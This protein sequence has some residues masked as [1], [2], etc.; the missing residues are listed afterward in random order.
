MK[1]LIA[2]LLVLVMVTAVFVGCSTEEEETTTAAPETT[3]QAP[4]TTTE[5]PET[6]TEETPAEKTYNVLLLVPKTG[7]KSYFDGAALGMTLLEETYDNVTTEIITMGSTDEDMA[8]YPTFFRDACESGKYDLIVTGAAECTNALVEVAAEYPDQL[9]FDFD[10][11][12]TFGNE[13]PNVYG[14]YYKTYDMGYLAGFL[15][16]QI[17]T[18]DM[19]YANEQKVIGAVVGIDFP[20]LNDFVGSFCQAAIDCGVQAI[21]SYCNTFTE[22]QPAYDC[23]MEL[24]E[25]G[26]DVVWQVAGSAG[27]GVFEASMDAGFYAFGVD[28]DQVD[29]VND[30][31]L[32]ANIV[33]SFQKDYAQMILAAFNSVLDGTFVGGTYDAVGLGEH[34]VGL[35]DNEQYRALVPQTIRDAVDEVYEKVK[36][37]EIV[38]LSAML[39]QETWATVRDQA[40]LPVE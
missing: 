13:L 39:D 26:C 23:A 4:E 31:T 18:S 24:Y 5:A 10:Y 29:T 15:A 19:E 38:P 8:N 37:G 11:Q 21:I 40:A 20:D 16:A 12:D 9:F 17:T 6:T 36:N 7:D 33:T 1:K 32:T 14:V 34:G 28:V 2:L 35:V 22:T 30:A 25:Q 27:L 3:T